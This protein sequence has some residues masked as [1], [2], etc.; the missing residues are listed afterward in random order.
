MIALLPLAFALAAPEAGPDQSQQE[1]RWNTLITNAY[2]C[3]PTQ[4]PQL[5]RAGGEHL[6]RFPAEARAGLA[7]KAAK[8]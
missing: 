8:Y 2:E 3:R 1:G 7:A 4:T 6:I 5:D